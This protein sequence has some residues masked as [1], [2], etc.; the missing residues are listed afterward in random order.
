M[1]TLAKNAIIPIAKSYVTEVLVQE[2]AN[3]LT[4]I[5]RSAENYRTEMTY[6]TSILPEFPVVTEMYGV[7][8]SFGPQLITEISD[9]C[10]FEWKQALVAFAGIDP[11]SN[12]SDEKNMRSN[13]SSMRGSLYLRKT[14]FNVV[15]I[16]LKCTSADKLIY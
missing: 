9:M 3:Y 6:L 15:S 14:Q 13:K 10:R 16:Y 5:S 1:Y 11:M 7:G 12:Q 2:A 8:K 4:S